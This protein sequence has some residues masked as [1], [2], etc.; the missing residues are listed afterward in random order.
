[1]ENY[2]KG[3]LLDASS[4]IDDE[5]LESF[6]L[7]GTREEVVERIVDYKKAGLELP[8]LQPI[9]MKHDDV[10]NVLGAGKILIGSGQS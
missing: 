2:F 4:N 7:V 6:S 5:M 10:K 8:I 3:N 9:S 1:A